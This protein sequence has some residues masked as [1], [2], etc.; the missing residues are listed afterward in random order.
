LN[1]Y[2]INQEIAL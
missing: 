2:P 1:K